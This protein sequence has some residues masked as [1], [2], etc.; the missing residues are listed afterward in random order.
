MGIPGPS[1]NNA[2][3][4]PVQPSAFAYNGAEIAVSIIEA[5]IKA[6]IA[7]ALANV[8]DYY[9]DKEV[10]TE[11]PVA[12]F[13]YETAQVYRCPA[14]FT[15]MR[16]LDLRDSEQLPNHINSADDILVAVIVEDRL[17]R[18]TTHKAWRYQAALMQCLH[19]VTL[20]SADLTL[21]LFS[22]VKRCSFSETVS[23]KSEADE[24]YFRKEVSLQLQVDHI[25]PLR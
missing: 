21:K 22:R 10:T 7:Q 16:D 5:Q 20:T 3:L 13:Q 14:V 25:E 12:Y 23:L 6:S 11:P 8:R 9:G 2:N 15:I 18:L 1:G 17:D 19:R 24:G 4:E